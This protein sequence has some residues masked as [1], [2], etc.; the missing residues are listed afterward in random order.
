LPIV[1]IDDA[2]VGA[3]RPGPVAKRLRELYI[4]EARH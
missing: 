3:G 4:N 2:I 1:R